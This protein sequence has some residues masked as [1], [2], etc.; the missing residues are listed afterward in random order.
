M[1][2]WTIPVAGGTTLNES[3]ADRPHLRNS[4]RSALRWNSFSELICSAFGELNAS[5]CTEWSMTRSAGTCGLTLLA[6]DASPVMRTTA[7]RMAARSTTAG[8]PVKSWRTT[9]AGLY[10]ISASPTFLAS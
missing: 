7:D 3:N 10:A 5:T 6:V 4:Y 2:W 8:T 1:T 9:R